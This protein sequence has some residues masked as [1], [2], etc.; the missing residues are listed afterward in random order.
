MTAESITGLRRWQPLLGGESAAKALAAVDEIAAG[1]RAAT[2][3]PPAGLGL[4]EAALWQAALGSGDAGRSL[5]FAYLDFHLHGVAAGADGETGADQPD[6]PGGDHAATAVDLLDRA[7]DGLAVASPHPG[8]FAGLPG[9][10]WVSEH[11]RDRLFDQDAAAGDAADEAVLAWLGRSCWT[12]DHD[13][14]GGLAGLGIYALERLP[15][16][17]AARALD[18]VVERLAASAAWTAE[19]AAWFT[20]ADRLPPELS[21]ARP[22]GARDLGAAHGASGVVALLG[23]AIAADAATERALPLLED[24]VRQLLSD[25]QPDRM[26]GQFPSFVAAGGEV[27]RSRLAWCYGDLGI[28]ATLAVAGEGARRADWRRTA[29][30]IA[31]AAATR[32]HAAAG[33]IDAGLCH[34]AAGVAHLFNRLHQASGDPE[35][36]EAARRWFHRALEL[37]RPGRGIGGFRT[38]EAHAGGGGSWHDDHGFLSGAAGIGL[39]LL[40]AVSPVEPNWDRALLLSLRPVARSSAHEPRG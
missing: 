26:H 1:L 40:A 35:L 3:A 33:V 13:L 23:A 12:G 6:E 38:W 18:L 29:N 8:L 27:R 19:G 25:R 15:R 11:L 14:I 36:G 7:V 28:A 4:A 20:P 22:H 16:P 21:Q 5:F 30:E 10:A 17:G 32:P 39:A 34:G 2:P 37:R 24:A 9:I 31:R